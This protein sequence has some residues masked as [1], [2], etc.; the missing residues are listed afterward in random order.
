MH[1]PPLATPDQLGEFRE[2]FRLL[3]VP[4]FY[5]AHA[6]RLDVGQDGSVAIRWVRLNGRGG[7]SPG[8]VAR[9]GSRRLRSGEVRRFR[10]ALA[11]ATLGSVPRE[12]DDIGPDGEPLSLCVDGTYFVLEHVTASGRQFIVRE[13]GIDEVAIRNLARVVFGFTPDSMME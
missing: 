3:V 1:E 2:Q 5:P 11:A 7:Y 4:T 9:R 8:T 12:I 10:S 6:Y 13:C